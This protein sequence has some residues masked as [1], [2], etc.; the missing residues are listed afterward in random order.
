MGMDESVVY[1]YTGHCVCVWLIT[2][3]K[4]CPCEIFEERVRICVACMI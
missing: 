4:V 1:T 2:H 3:Y